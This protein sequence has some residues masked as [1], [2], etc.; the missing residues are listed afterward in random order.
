L[1]AAEASHPGVFIKQPIVIDVVATWGPVT[2]DPGPLD[3]EASLRARL[4][5]K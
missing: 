4:I 2:P 5:K 1:D 3:G